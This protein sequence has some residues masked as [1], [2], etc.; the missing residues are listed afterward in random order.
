MRER[1]YWTKEEQLRAAFIADRKESAFLLR[2]LIDL[3]AVLSM[4]VKSSSRL[5][6]EKTTELRTRLIE[7]EEETERM[8]ANCL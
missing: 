3:R 2:E 8:E 6:L 4:T 5:F 7:Y 1:L